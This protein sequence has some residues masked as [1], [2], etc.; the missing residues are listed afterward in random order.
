MNVVAA[1]TKF[2]FLKNRL[3]NIFMSGFAFD[4]KRTFDILD[5]NHALPVILKYIDQ[6]FV[7]NKHSYDDQ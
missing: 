6:D 5:L 7:H 2:Y 3:I 4:F 1:N